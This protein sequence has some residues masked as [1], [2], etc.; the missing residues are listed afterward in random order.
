[1]TDKKQPMRDW[2]RNYYNNFK[3]TNKKN[4][5]TENTPS[6]LTLDVDLS[7]K[8]D[9]KVAVTKALEKKNSAN[10]GGLNP[11]PNPTNTGSGPNL[12]IGSGKKKAKIN[13]QKN[14][15]RKYLKKTL[16]RKKTKRTYSRKK[17]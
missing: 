11:N 14:K 3:F 10:G 9:V 2:A 15:K 1:M 13:T 17:I 5:G 6:N 7:D 4:K 8:F 12:M 16:P